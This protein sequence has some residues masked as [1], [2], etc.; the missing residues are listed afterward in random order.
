MLKDRKF[1]FSDP[2]HFND[3]IDCKIGIFSALK[4]AIKVA[5]KEDNSIKNRLDKMG[6]LDKTLK[7]IENTVK[8]SGVFSLSKEQ[9]NIL[10]W[11]HY[12]DSH[13][14][15]S[16]GFELSSN[17]TKYNA[18]NSIVGT[19]EVQYSESNP[20]V[21]RFLELAEYSDAPKWEEFWV[22]FI[23]IG[24]LAKSSTWEYENEVR[25]IRATPGKV[26]YSYEE[27]KEVIFGLNMTQK[28]KNKLKNILSSSK[29]DHVITKEVIREND[30]FKLVV[31][32][33]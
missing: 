33:C 2:K 7:K 31:V 16:L 24:L 30:G 18:E 13:K 12:A 8:K 20:F 17:F 5:E 11:S 29:W 23:S 4:A 25:I 32:N 22:S 15:F 10:M 6:D 1:Y 19:D 21:E 26:K 9:N 28:R 3:P 27:L 14:G